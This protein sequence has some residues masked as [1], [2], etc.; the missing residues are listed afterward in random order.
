MMNGAPPA[1]LPVLYWT[2]VTLLIIWN[3]VASGQAARVRRAPPWLASLT[4]AAG[5]L[6][7]PAILVALLGTSTLD[8][9]TLHVI[10]WLW[11]LTAILAALQ[12]GATLLSRQTASWIALPLT[13]YGF[14]VASL[15][16]SRWLVGMGVDPGLGGASLLAAQQAVL[17]PLLGDA[18]MQTGRALLI[19]A[20]APL[21]PARWILGQIARPLL[22]VGASACA[23]L[24]LLVAMPRAVRAVLGFESFALSQV[25][26]RTEPEL[27]T[28]LRIFGN[29]GGPPAALSIRNDLALVDSLS[30]GVVLVTVRPS[31]TSLRALD[32]L[33]RVLRPFRGD[34]V[35]L[36]VAVALGYERGDSKLMRTSPDSL[37]ALR[38]EM[39]ARIVRAL[40]P[41]VVFP[42]QLPLQEGWRELGSMP[43]DWLRTYYAEASGEIHRLRPR[44]RVGISMGAFGARDSVLYQW[45]VSEGSPVDLVAFEVFP[46][47]D[48][49]AGFEARLST[50]SR[51]LER[52]AGSTKPHWLVAGGYPYVFGEASQQLSLRR[53]RAWASRTGS[54]RA[55]VIADAADYDRL[56]GL[57]AAGG[58]I[59]FDLQS[60]RSREAAATSLMSVP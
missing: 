28:G 8:G 6:V 7:P 2:G 24:L 34:S 47:V 15:A 17:T 43:D 30:A 49:A 50:A 44:T 13:A 23:T 1:L 12:C 19:P 25:A 42:A 56:T 3:L 21:F 57:R 14:L 54:V 41:D 58:R 26:D 31:G 60:L 33:D 35:P 55:L 9:R 10:G 22:S 20:V 40:R 52:D 11:P 45:A 51:W 16:V 32:S 48:G 4:S 18:S 39:T 36:Q 5:F 38:L 46:T 29:L 37:M 27:L 59:R 53:A